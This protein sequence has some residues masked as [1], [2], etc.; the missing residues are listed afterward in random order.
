MT[1]GWLASS[2]GYSSC[3]KNDYDITQTVTGGAGNTYIETKAAIDYRY[4]SKAVVELTSTGSGTYSVSLS[5]SIIPYGFDSG[6]NNNTYNGILIDISKGGSAAKFT[7][8]TWAGGSAIS[9]N[10]YRKTVIRRIWL[11]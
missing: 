3:V 2:T 10:R 11:E 7:I 5:A 4:Y 9:G 1:G 6:E 8:R